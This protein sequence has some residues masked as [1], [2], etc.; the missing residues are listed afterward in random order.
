MPRWVQKV[1]REHRLLLKSEAIEGIKWLADATA[2]FEALGIV[3][4]SGQVR[5]LPPGSAE[6]KR[7]HKIVQA[8]EQVTEEPLSDINLLARYSADASRLTFTKNRKRFYVTMPREL[9]ALKLVPSKGEY[10]VIFV[11]RNALEIWRIEN[12]NKRI[13]EAS[14]EVEELIAE[15]AEDLGVDL[16]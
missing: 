13:Q 4:E 6:S 3:G 15:S 9:R 1:E 14:K 2:S 11:F 12:W 16:P 7:L 10:A 8:L 5:V